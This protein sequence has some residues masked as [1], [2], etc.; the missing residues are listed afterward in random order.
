MWDKAL[1]LLDEPD[2]KEYDAYALTMINA[3]QNDLAALGLGFASRTVPKQLAAVGEALEIDELTAQA[4]LVYGVTALL[5]TN[6]DKKMTNYF[7]E[8]YE[9][10]KQTA[11]RYAAVTV[12]AMEDVYAGAR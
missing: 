8:K 9:A 4:V 2:S 7:E 12:S 6:A 11:L 3:V 10:A 1:Q 5:S